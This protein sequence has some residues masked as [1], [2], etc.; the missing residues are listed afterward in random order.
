[1]RDLTP[2]ENCPSGSRLQRGAPRE[3][4][5]PSDETCAYTQSDALGSRY[6]VSGR[7]NGSQHRKWGPPSIAY[8]RLE[9]PRLPIV[10]LGAGGNYKFAIRLL[11]E[12]TRVSGLVTTSEG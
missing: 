9:F 11:N 2:Y 5:R 8:S 1:M 10:S 7:V 12:E 3:D 4:V 6:S